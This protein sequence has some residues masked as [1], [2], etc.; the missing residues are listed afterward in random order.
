EA[1]QAAAAAGG[2][3][4]DTAV[5]LFWL[6][7]GPSQLDTYDMKPDAPAE[8]RGLWR[9]IPTN[10][11][12]IDITEMFPRQ[13]KVADKFAIVRS[14]HHDTGDHWTG[15]HM[16]LTGRG[17]PTGLDPEPRYPSVGAVAAKLCGPR[18]AGIPP[19]VA[20]PQAYTVGVR[21]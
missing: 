18:R 15:A 13:A 7:G 17:G 19:Y 1:R 11:P 4:K 20:I 8:Y 14:L 12:G 9:P 6:D 10:V 2:S 16:V 21:P 5:I 3:Q